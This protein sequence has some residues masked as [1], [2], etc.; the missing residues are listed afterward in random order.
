MRRSGSSSLPRNVEPWSSRCT[1]RPAIPATA[2]TSAL[3][4]T[5]RSR[6]GSS[7]G[8]GAVRVHDARG[9]PMPARSSPARNSSPARATSSCQPRSARG[10]ARYYTCVMQAT[11]F[12]V[13]DEGYFVGTVGLIN[14]LRLTGHD[15]EIVILDCGFT[16]DQRELLDPV[17]TLERLD[18]DR[19]TSFRSFLKP[20]APLTHQSDH[21]IVIDSDVIVT[22]RLDELIAS[23]AAGN[24][25]AYPDPER[26]RWFAEWKDIFQLPE[27]PRRDIYV[28]AAV[29]GFSRSHHPEFLQQWWGAC[30]RILTVP[31]MGADGAPA[32]TSQADQD[33]LNAVLMSSYPEGTVDLRPVPE[34]PQESELRKGVDIDDPRTLRCSYGGQPTRLLHSAGRRKPW[35]RRGALKYRVHNPSRE[36]ARC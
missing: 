6:T 10:R 14:S 1:V 5:S 21:T 8:A 34:A 22:S 16:P 15:G 2:R 20:I 19:A 13:G 36:A 35:M 9:A 26:D 24:I 32:P 33:A 17:C 27:H 4:V 29:V 28:C 30:Q 18:D 12:S 31:T 7:G 11:I 3:V 25:V 23:A